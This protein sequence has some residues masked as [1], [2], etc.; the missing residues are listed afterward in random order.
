MNFTLPLVNQQSTVHMVSDIDYIDIDD[1]TLCLLLLRRRDPLSKSPSLV[2]VACLFPWTATL[3]HLDLQ[4]VRCSEDSFKRECDSGA[5]DTDDDSESPL[6]PHKAVPDSLSFLSQFPSLQSL[7]LS[8]VYPE[9]ISEDLVGCTSLQKLHIARKPTPVNRAPSA[10]TLLVILPNDVAPPPHES[11][12]AMVHL[13][14]RATLREF[15]DHS[16]QR[17]ILCPAGGVGHILQPDL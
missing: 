2:H 9:V 10:M 1:V 5:L 11:G 15:R 13:A 12:P 7:H 4:D 3:R 8:D 6:P 16:T 17:I 14:A